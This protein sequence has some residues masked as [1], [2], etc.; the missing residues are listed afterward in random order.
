MKDKTFSRNLET[1]RIERL[2]EAKAARMWWRKRS[3]HRRVPACECVQFGSLAQVTGGTSQHGRL[4][5]E[6][7]Q[8]AIELDV[9]GFTMD[10]EFGAV[11]DWA[12]WTGSSATCHGRTS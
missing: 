9:D 10:W 3:W 6:V 11:M 4:A 12:S 7:L 5:Q 8:R 2:S 1:A